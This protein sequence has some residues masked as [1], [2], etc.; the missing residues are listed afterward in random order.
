V[1]LIFGI[2]NP[3][4]KYSNTRHNAGFLLIDFIAQKNSLSFKASKN[5]Y[6]FAEGKTAECGFSLI[7]PAT[8]V[9]DS[10]IAALQAIEE[11]KIPLSDFLVLVD[12]VNT[13]P[14][15]FRIRSGGGDGG[16]NG[17]NSIIYHLNSNEFP[18]IRIGIGNS[19]G[20][21]EMI[22]YVL[23]PF[24]NEDEKL[25]LTAFK[26]SALLIE[27]FIKGGTKA[28]LNANSKLPTN[29]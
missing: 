4:K 3:G 15:K 10:G 17:L 13:E 29:P 25:L 27:E 22:D 26:D 23:S 18:R 19:F 14:G 28:M 7:K 9:N 8:Y 16:H 2:G 20:K 12:D 24:T 21:G 6:Y 11:Y 5:D 1:R